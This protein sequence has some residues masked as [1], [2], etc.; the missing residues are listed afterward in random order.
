MDD[1][2]VSLWDEESAAPAKQSAQETESG[3]L[4]LW[5][6][7]LDKLKL[8]QEAQEENDDFELSLFDE[9]TSLPSPVLPQL[10][11][12]ALDASIV[13]EESTPTVAAPTP[14]ERASSLEP[15][16]SLSP[17]SK[18]VKSVQADN[19]D[20][21]L[22]LTP[23]EQEKGQDEERDL[24]TEEPDID[25]LWEQIEAQ[26]ENRLGEAARSEPSDLVF[27][28]LVTDNNV[29]VDLD[30]QPIDDSELTDDTKEA[31]ANPFATRVEQAE[32]EVNFELLL[33]LN[34]QFEKT[35]PEFPTFV[36]PED[37]GISNRHQAA[38]PPLD[39]S[40]DGDI[41]L[42]SLSGFPTFAAD[43]EPDPKKRLTSKYIDKFARDEV[44]VFLAPAD[45]EEG[46]L[47]SLRTRWM[48]CHA[49]IN[50][51]QRRC[52]AAY[53]LMVLRFIIF[54]EEENIPPEERFPAASEVI[55]AWTAVLVHEYSPSYARTHLN[56]LQF[57]Y[58]LHR[59]TFPVGSDELKTYYRGGDTALGKTMDERR[60][61]VPDDLSKIMQHWFQQAGQ[62]D[63]DFRRS[64]CLSAALN[65]GF[66]GMCRRK[67]IT[68]DRQK[69]QRPRAAKKKDGEPAKKKRRIVSSK[70][71]RKA[72]DPKYDASGASFKFTKGSAKTPRVLLF[73]LPWCKKKKSKGATRYI[74]E[75]TKLGDFCNP[76]RMVRW[77]L[78]VNK[79]TSDEF[80]FSWTGRDGVS[81][82][83]LTAAF[84]KH[85]MDEACKAVGI[86]PILGHALRCGGKTFYE[87]S[88]VST[89]LVMIHGDWSTTKS[90]KRYQRFIAKTL[91]KFSSNRVVSEDEQRELFSD[92]GVGETD[93]ERDSDDLDED[94]DEPLEE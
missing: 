34:N 69:D 53:A 83:K 85:R 90:F 56:A 81:R 82:M 55:L 14:E 60:P 84:F 61:A 40:R 72:F 42:A 57:L 16:L 52:L 68:V 71:P 48:M 27:S 7:P 65:V 2:D 43:V 5:D 78:A 33:T 17:S 49:V 41:S 86:P 62:D 13:L 37:G 73:H 89:P 38:V 11:E 76:L 77:H 25:F 8:P 75:Q 1:F 15:N 23:D 4:G 35:L 24:G 3:D 29:S 12:E 22:D 87:M 47:W 50:S 54:C 88:G 44:L 28:D 39:A 66:F 93:S 45:Y 20:D 31:L 64:I 18:P 10:S 79:P 46:R 74:P 21:W 80:A 32:Q 30:L 59:R 51:V 92:N 19:D 91:S 67:D 6:E 36:E 94:D 26:E 58:K 63:H 70:V 9:P